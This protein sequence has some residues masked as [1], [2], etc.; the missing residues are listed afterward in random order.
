MIVGMT[1]VARDCEGGPHVLQGPG[2][3]AAMPE[4]DLLDAFTEER[5]EVRLAGVGGRC[6]DGNLLPSLGG[7]S[8]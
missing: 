8:D 4:V 2:P 6:E 7:A 5:P 1:W 3:V